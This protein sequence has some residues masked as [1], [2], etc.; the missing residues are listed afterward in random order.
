MKRYR[1]LQGV[2]LEELAKRVIDLGGGPS[3]GSLQQ[4]E[5]GLLSPGRADGRVIAQALGTTVKWLLESGTSSDAPDE[6]KAPPTREELEVEEEAVKRRVLTAA[7][8]V[9]NARRRHVRAKEQVEAARQQE[10]L[11]FMVFD[12]LSTQLTE[13]QIDYQYVLGRIDSLRA[14]SGEETIKQAVFIDAADEAA[15]K[16][17]SLGAKLSEARARLGL[18]P[19]QV[20]A[21]AQMLPSVLT[22]IELDRFDVLGEDVSVRGHIRVLARAYGME[23]GPLIAQYDAQHGD[24][25]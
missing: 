12:R 7:S 1:L 16:E 24:R 10:D 6:M 4:M 14:A 20:A 18:T 13:L 2:S 19:E 3:L 22:A 23:A 5:K 11:A 15:S 17:T 8:E 25:K 9:A 21:A